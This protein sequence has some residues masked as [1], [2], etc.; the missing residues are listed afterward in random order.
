MKNYREYY[1]ALYCFVIFSAAFVMCS[2][3]GKGVGGDQC[4]V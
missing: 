1:F 3:E 2:S 4:C